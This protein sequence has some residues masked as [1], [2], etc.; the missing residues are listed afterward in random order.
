MWRCV[1]TDAGAA[2]WARMEPI[3]VTRIDFGDGI[4]ASDAEAAGL[5]ALKHHVQD[6]NEGGSRVLNGVT[7]S[8][9]VVQSY[10]SYGG[11]TMEITNVG[12][13]RTFFLR[14]IG[15]W[16][17]DGDA[18]ILFGVSYT[19]TNPDGYELTYRK[20]SMI[21]Q[22]LSFLQSGEEN[23]LALYMEG[24]GVENDSIPQD[25]T[26]IADRAFSDRFDMTSADIPD[27]VGEIGDA[28]FD[29]TPLNT[30]RFNK[31]ARYN[32]HGY[33]AYMRIGRSAFSQ[34]GITALNLGQNTLEIG[35]GAFDFCENLESVTGYAQSI[36]I[37][38]FWY[39]T[40]LKTVTIETTLDHSGTMT[41]GRGAF[42]TVN[43]ELN[44]DLRGGKLVFASDGIQNQGIFGSWR[45]W[46]DDENHQGCS[47]R[48]LWLWFDEYDVPDYVFAASPYYLV[49]TDSVYFFDAALNLA[50]HRLQ[51]AYLDIHRSSDYLPLYSGGTQTFADYTF[52]NLTRIS[53]SE[54]AVIGTLRTGE[55][56]AAR[57]PKLRNL[58]VSSNC[59]FQTISDAAFNSNEFTQLYISRGFS[60]SIAANALQN[61]AVS[62]IYVYRGQDISDF[63]WGAK[64]R[65]GGDPV[66]HYLDS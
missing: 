39:C 23:E 62:G 49:A 32:G 48:R 15:I 8:T 18:E 35:D 56:D 22:T 52:F 41:V 54:D 11:I 58:T 3:R 40:N 24:A 45:N 60:A 65:P 59:G 21:R 28:A 37:H 13:E 51:P 29:S 66:L 5:T 20:E 31:R 43:N 6:W 53:L 34:T 1:A 10:G 55:L 7:Y 12:L 17:A 9:G 25:A 50:Q 36:G 4:I 38:A 47:I 42:D 27:A 61:V 14:E 57:V 44:L 16:V 2:K 64:G 63:P 26:K 33:A 19:T 30:L 46:R